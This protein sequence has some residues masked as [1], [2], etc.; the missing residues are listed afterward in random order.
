MGGAIELVHGVPILLSGTDGSALIRSMVNIEQWLGHVLSGRDILR[1]PKACFANTLGFVISANSAGG[2]VALL[3][4][5]AI[6]V[7]GTDMPE[8]SVSTGLPEAPMH[9]PMSLLMPSGL[10]VHGTI[11]YRSPG[12]HA[13]PKS[14]PPCNSTDDRALIDMLIEELNATFMCNLALEYCTSRDGTSAALDEISN[15]IRYI[16]VGASH[17]CRIASALREAGADVADLSVLA[18]KLSESNVETSVALLREV[19]DEEWEG[20]IVILHISSL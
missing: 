1:T 5:T 19:L 4:A 6:T 9:Y 3:N 14:V 8:A 18:W 13:L 2:N 11:L 7:P 16:I 17:A 15:G 10:T 20:E 12:Y